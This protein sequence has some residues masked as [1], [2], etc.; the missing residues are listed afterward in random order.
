MASVMSFCRHR[1]QM[2]YGIFVA[3]DQE[4]EL[5]HNDE[6]LMR[7]RIEVFVCPR[8]WL[9]VRLTDDDDAAQPNFYF[10]VLVEGIDI[11]FYNE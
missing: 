9:F 11:N 6:I 8:K 1:L 5:A 3:F 2:E 4:I 10:M 7:I